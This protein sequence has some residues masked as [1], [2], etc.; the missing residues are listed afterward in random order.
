MKKEWSDKN[1]LIELDCARDL[2]A[3]FILLYHFV[4][5]SSTAGYS[6]FSPF[7]IQAFSLLGN[8]GIDLFFCFL[9]QA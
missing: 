1:R 5:E 8:I 6:Y 9:V 2:A 4:I 3:I 7:A